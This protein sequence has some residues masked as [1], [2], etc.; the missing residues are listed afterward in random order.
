M[1]PTPHRHQALITA[2]AADTNQG[3]WV[4]FY[5][6]SKP[7][8]LRMANTAGWDEDAIY[9]LHPVDMTPNWVVWTGQECPVHPES[10]IVVIFG[11]GEVRRTLA[12][13]LNWAMR[14]VILCY[15]VIKEHV[16]ANP[17]QH[18]IDEH[19]LHPEKVVQWWHTD[20]KEWRYVRDNKPRWHPTA[21]YR[22][23]L[24]HQELRDMAEYGNWNP[25]EN[26]GDAL[27]LAV[28]L[29]LVIEVGYA[30]RGF[31]VVRTNTDNWQEFREA[32][33]N[34]PY[35]ATRRAIVRAAAAIGKELK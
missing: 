7:N 15:Q 24:P 9:E 32:W 12:D 29:G 21:I 11:D 5:K 23:K 19:K 14:G 2:W 27:R 4:F 3:R 18:M 25:L 20:C 13:G 6:H 10:E 16:E 22:F 33:G 17:H 31:L 1:T 8:W 30:A 28:D 34:D 35:A 26:D